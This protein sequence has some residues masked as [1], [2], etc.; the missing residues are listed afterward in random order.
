MVVSCM[1]Y[2]DEIFFWFN[3][4]LNHLICG[5]FISKK[6]NSRYYFNL[7]QRKTNSTLHSNPNFSIYSNFPKF[8]TVQLIRDDEERGVK[9][10][11]VELPGFIKEKMK[12]QKFRN[13][14]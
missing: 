12:E 1:G 6:Q 4:F 5:D 7:L 14:D 10:P 11:E 9:M 2:T 13:K 8:L 3:L